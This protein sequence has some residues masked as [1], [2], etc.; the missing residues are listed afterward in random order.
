MLELEGQVALVTG[1]S[2]G[3]GAAIALAFAKQGASVVLHGRDENALAAMA[4]QVRQIGGPVITVRGDVTDSGDIE[5]MRSRIDSELSPVDVLVANA[6]GSPA[7]PGPLEELSLDAWTAT[8][9]GN[10]TATFLRFARFF[11]G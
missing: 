2:R 4:A 1:S 11:R 10:L 5:A 8:L 3:I 9:H 7:R 6:G